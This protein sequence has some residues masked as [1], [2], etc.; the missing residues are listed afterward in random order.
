MYTHGIWMK[1]IGEFCKLYIKNCS[2]ENKRYV[3]HKT[4]PQ[5]FTCLIY[6]CE[7]IVTIFGGISCA[8]WNVNKARLG[9]YYIHCTLSMEVASDV[10]WNTVVW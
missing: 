6:I 1:I 3:V 9:I 4:I 5:Q 10:T 2:Y 7:I 8:P